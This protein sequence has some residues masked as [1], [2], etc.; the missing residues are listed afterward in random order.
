MSIPPKGWGAVE[1]LIWDYYCELK[2][3]NNVII[4]NDK[5]TNN[6]INQITNIKPDVVHIQYDEFVSIIQYIKYSCK[7]IALTSHFGYITQKNKWSSYH[8]IYNQILTSFD[9]NVFQFCLSNEIKQLLISDGY[10]AQNIYV[11]PNGVNSKLFKFTENPKNYD[12]SIYLAKI[13]YRK[14]QSKFINIESL[15]FA[16]NC[17]DPDFDTSNKRYLGEWSKE[18]LYQNLTDYGNLVLLSDGEADPLVVKEALVAGLGIVISEFATANLDLTKEF[19]NVIPENK[20]N[21]I[22]YVE[23]IIIKNREYSIKHRNEIREYGLTFCWTNIVDKYIDLLYYL[24]EKCPSQQPSLLY[25]MQSINKKK[26][27]KKYK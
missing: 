22:Q 25:R 14:R 2:K 8:T 17:S 15:Y 19:I 20:I 1:I 23:Q 27:L 7:I 13:D 12:K 4:I 16:G 5:N 3:N 10:P 24:L 9:T 18:Y 21:D 26:L 6:I 11:T